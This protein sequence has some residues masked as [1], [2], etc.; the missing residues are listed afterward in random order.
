LLSERVRIGFR[1]VAC[2]KYRFGIAGPV[3]IR[4][5]VAVVVV[6]VDTTLGGPAR[7]DI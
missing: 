5:L 7:A 2:G 3:V 1:R 6:I 4:R